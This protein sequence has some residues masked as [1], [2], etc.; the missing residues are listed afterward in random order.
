MQPTDKC[1]CRD[2]LT[3]VGD[4]DQLALEVA[5]VGFEIV[6]L[7]HLD[8]EKVMIVSLRLPARCVLGEERFGYL[9]EVK[10]RM[11]RQGVELI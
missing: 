8:G 2:V 5:D 9:L 7:S 1:E 11:W 4:L 3:V 10:E 6:T